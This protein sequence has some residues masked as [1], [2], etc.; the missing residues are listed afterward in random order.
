MHMI[1]TVTRHEGGQYKCIYC[2]ECIWG[3]VV[4]TKDCIKKGVDGVCV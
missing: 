4:K 2:I 3:E 1:T